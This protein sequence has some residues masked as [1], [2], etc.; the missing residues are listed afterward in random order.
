MGER[1]RSRVTDGSQTIPVT[2]RGVIPDTFT[3]SV[4]VVVEGRYNRDGTFVATTLLAKCASRYENA[5]DK[6]QS[7]PGVQGGEGPGGVILLGELSL[8][9][10][11][12]MATWSATVSFA[13]GRM[14]RTDLVA[15]GERAM[16]ATFAFVVL[17]VDRTVDGA[18]HERLLAPVRRVVHEREPAD[19][20]QVLRVLGRAGRLDAV[21]VPDALALLGD[22]A[23]RESADAIAS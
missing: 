2:Y 21:L 1:C 16:Y 7:T 20:L 23:G 12:L 4:D 22:H 8:W 11:L 5:P 9:V 18:A 19:G 3:D 15:S 6:Y 14:R 10:A 17:V 13:G